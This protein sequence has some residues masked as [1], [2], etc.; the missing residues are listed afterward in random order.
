[1]LGNG[2]KAT[3]GT[4]GMVGKLGSGGRVGLGRDGWVVGKVG[5]L[6]CGRVGMV[7]KSGNVGFGKFV[8]AGR[9]GNCRRWRAAKPPLMLENDKAKKK[10]R[11]LKHLKEVIIK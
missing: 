5:K 8:T 7:G 2:G 11:T 10:A 4:A 9:G 1:M 3:F 6:G